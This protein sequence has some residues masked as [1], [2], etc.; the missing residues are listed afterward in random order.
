MAFCAGLP[1]FQTDHDRPISENCQKKHLAVLRFG[2]SAW[3]AD[4]ASAQ[5]ICAKVTCVFSNEHRMWIT[6]SVEPCPKK[7][8]TMV[9]KLF[10]IIPRV[11]D[12]ELQFADGP[13]PM[14]SCYL[15]CI[16]A[17]VHSMFLRA[18]SGCAPF[19]I[20]TTERRTSQQENEGHTS[21]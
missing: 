1:H 16:S 15:H 17:D 19:V 2:V 10:C 6:K 14:D 8:Q 11:F 13:P 5:A 9:A 12:F 4:W 21:C 18:S 3:L 20:P 7:F